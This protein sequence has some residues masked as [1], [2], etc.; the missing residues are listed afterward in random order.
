MARSA[1]G[2]LAIHEAI[3]HGRTEAALALIP[4]YKPQDYNPD[5][6]RHG[7]PIC[8]AIGRGNA[9]V[10]QGFL[11]AGL[12]PNSAAFSQEPLLIQA[13]RAG[14]Q[15]IVRLLLQA[16]ADKTAKDTHGKTA[17]DYANAQIAP[18]LK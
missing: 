12:D 17:A 5:G 10:V 1:N 15:E 14:R 8:M 2:S 13:V 4:A 16:G 11:E 3:W 9:R 18:L 6:L 7:Y